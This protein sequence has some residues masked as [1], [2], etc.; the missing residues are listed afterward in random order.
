MIDT[1]ISTPTT[2]L[3]VLTLVT[4]LFM[5]QFPKIRG[6]DPKGKRGKKDPDL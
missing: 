2:L 5:K 3:T 1:V 6:S 4:A